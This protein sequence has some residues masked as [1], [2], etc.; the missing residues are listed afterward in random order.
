MVGAVA[1]LGLPLFAVVVWVFVLQ[2]ALRAARARNTEL[3]E[4]LARSQSE[5]AAARAAANEA[6]TATEAAQAEAVAAR[7]EAES[8]RADAA[9]ARQEADELRD[10]VSV[11]E[12]AVAELTQR[13]ADLGEWAGAVL[14]TEIRRIDRLWRDRLSLPGEPSPLGQLGDPAAAAARVFAELSRE[15][16]GVAIDVTWSL[17]PMPTPELTVAVVKVVEELVAA[18]ALADGASLVAISDGDQI[19]IRLDPEPPIDPPD[20]LV[21]ALA[22]MGWA[23]RREGDVLVAAPA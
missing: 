22:G 21:Q 10:R 16:R 13:V 1:V 3:A 14:T 8:A 2:R 18:A 20:G 19:S 15:D 23:L 11:A 4:S 7:A 12:G 17:E 5:T 9:A 6:Q